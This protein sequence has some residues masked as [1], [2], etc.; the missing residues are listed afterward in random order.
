MTLI[1]LRLSAEST[2]RNLMD[3]AVSVSV[4]LQ[5]L[6]RHRVC[7]RSRSTGER[8]IA[9]SGDM[10]PLTLS[11]TMCGP[12]AP[13][14]VCEGGSLVRCAV[15]RTE[16]VIERK[17][18]YLLTGAPA[19]GK[20]TV[21]RRLVRDVR[22]LPIFDTDL[23]GSS[24]HLDW[25]AWATSWLLVAHGL[26][27]TGLPTVLCGYGLSRTKVDALAARPLLGPIRVCNLDLR[28]ELLRDRLRRRPLCDEAR[29]ERKVAAARVLRAEADRNLDVSG[30][31]PTVV[32]TR[33]GDWLVH[34]G[35][36]AR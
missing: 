3:H 19:T 14:E 17:P 31:P 15:C 20:S 7:R 27:Q 8:P 35:A 10:E 25:A 24:A 13:V 21:A 22:G 11:C 16:H 28:E 1:G 23:F 33:V 2:L 18:L 6:A 5:R 9:D 32:V 36:I 29:I 34:E 12:T 4:E 30:D 26:A